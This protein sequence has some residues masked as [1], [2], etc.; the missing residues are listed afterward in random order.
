VAA[1]L[2]A[3]GIQTGVHYP[4]PLPLLQ[5]YSRLNARP[6]QFPVAARNAARILSL[7][8]YPELTRQQVEFVA[9]SLSVAT[10]AADR[11]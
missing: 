8:I 5:A 2:A 7:P 10:R 11:P 4:V 1:R 9:D 3:R 6:E